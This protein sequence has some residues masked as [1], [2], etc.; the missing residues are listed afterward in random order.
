MRQ[1]RRQADTDQLKP[2]EDPH[3]IAQRRVQRRVDDDADQRDRHQRAR[4]AHADRVLAQRVEPQARQ[5]PRR[6]RQQHRLRPRRRPRSWPSR[7]SACAQPTISNAP[8]PRRRSPPQGSRER[9]RARRARRR[10]EAR[11]V[12]LRGDR[13]DTISG[14]RDQPDAHRAQLVEQHDRQ[15]AGGQRLDAKRTDHHDV[16]VV[17]ATC[18]S[19]VNAIGVASAN[20]CRLAVPVALHRP[21]D[22]IAV[23]LVNIA[24][25]FP[26]AGAPT[27]TR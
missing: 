10:R 19:C 1:R 26:K 9:H 3:A 5:Q 12:L 20:N 17:N 23:I 16:V 25:G 21:A 22:P 11:R 24:L 13:R 2:R 4:P 7:A 8:R 15:T 14:R 27:L 18:A 6:E